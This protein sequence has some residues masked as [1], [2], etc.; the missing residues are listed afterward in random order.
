MFPYFL[1]GSTEGE[2]GA[3]RALPP[4][5]AAPLRAVTRSLRAV[6]SARLRGPGAGRRH[7]RVLG[8]AV[9]QPL[10]LRGHAEGGCGALGRPERPRAAA[11]AALPGAYGPVRPRGPEPELGAGQKAHPAAPLGRRGGQLHRGPALRRLSRPGAGRQQRA[12]A[13]VTPRVA[14]GGLPAALFDV[15][16]AFGGGRYALRG[17][18]A[19]WAFGWAVG[20]T[21][22]G[23]SAG[24][25]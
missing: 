5:A 15:F 1:S 24:V 2:E 12:A 9:R 23:H 14:A 16:G 21:D 19:A 4:A 8:A 25:F 22:P 10:R 18:G 6:G 11:A 20:S 13:P 17:R 3:G 7:G